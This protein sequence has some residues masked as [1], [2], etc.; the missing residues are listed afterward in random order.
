[1]E[2]TRLAQCEHRYDPLLGGWIPVRGE[3]METTVPNIYAAG[4]CA[5]V[6]GSFVAVEE[7]RIAGLAAAQALGHLSVEECKRHMEPS[8]KRLAGLKRLRRALDEISMPRPGLYNLAKDDTIVCRC[9]EITLGEIKEALAEGLTD[10]NEVK[11]MTR[12]GMGHCQGRMCGPAVQEIIAREMGLSP[13]DIG[14]L[15]PRPPVRPVPMTAVARHTRLQPV[16]NLFDLR[17][18]PADKRAMQAR[19]SGREKGESLPCWM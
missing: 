6:A 10:M 15:N 16:E 1:V 12:M 3:N 13:M 4:D 18:F 19:R 11:R 9:E 5:G 8:R 17:A 7:G 14:Y 2:L